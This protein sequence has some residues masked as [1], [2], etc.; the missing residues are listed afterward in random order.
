MP[1][2]VTDDVVDGL[3]DGPGETSSGSEAGPI[4]VYADDYLHRQLW[5]VRTGIKEALAAL[6][7][8]L[9]E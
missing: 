5:D 7:I 6:R 3:P 4:I 1:A 8:W 2:G 9:A